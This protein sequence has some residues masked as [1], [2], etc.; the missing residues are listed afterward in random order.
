MNIEPGIVKTRMALPS[1]VVC[2]LLLFFTCCLCLLSVALGQQPP[3]TPN[4]TIV[5]LRKE[6]ESL[7]SAKSD[8]AFL[9]RYLAFLTKRGLG[10][11]LLK[12]DMFIVG[13]GWSIS[14]L[15]KKADQ[16]LLSGPKGQTRNMPKERCACFITDSGLQTEAPQ[17]RDARDA[18][19]VIVVGKHGFVVDMQE[20]LVRIFGEIQEP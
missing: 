11:T 2:G 9:E 19:V 12:G 8:D 18:V 16:F 17:G 1:T 13:H 3:A 15:D 14:G 20:G 5:A 7:V 4:S 10:I 6:V